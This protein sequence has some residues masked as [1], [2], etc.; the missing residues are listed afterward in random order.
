MP[1]M[2]TLLSE[3]EKYVKNLP[4]LKLPGIHSMDR[5]LHQDLELHYPI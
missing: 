5:V 1:A 3:L 4:K 2:S